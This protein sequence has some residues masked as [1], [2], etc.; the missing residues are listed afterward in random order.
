MVGDRKKWVKAWVEQGK[1]LD[2][3]LRVFNPYLH[4]EIERY[5]H[6]AKKG[7]L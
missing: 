4:A 1:E 6:Q 3:V 5:Y 7:N 2:R